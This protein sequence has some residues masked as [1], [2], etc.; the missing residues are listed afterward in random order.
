MNDYE[1]RIVVFMDML[2]FKN[3][4]NN[5]M[6]DIN[7]KSQVFKVMN[8]IKDIESR[9]YNGVLRLDEIGKE[10]TVFS[11]SIVI[12]YPCSLASAL[13]YILIDIIHIQIDLICNGILLRGGIAIGKLYHKGNIVFGPAMI[14][15]YLLESEKAKTP[16]IIIEPKSV[17]FGINVLPKINYK[18]YEHDAIY[19]LLKK[20]SDGHLFINFLEQTGELDYE[21]DIILILQNIKK[22]IIVGLSCECLEIVEKYEWLKNYYNEIAKKSPIF[23]NMLIN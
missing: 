13:Y 15:A 2:G 23:Q 9:N 19:G 4:I 6:L 8:I 14:Q 10:V 20:D 22:I 5:T 18:D 17:Q 21:G 1:D 12:S 7:Y 11:D 16:R 3:L